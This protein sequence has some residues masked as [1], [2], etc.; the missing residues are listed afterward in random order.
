M[1]G[2]ARGHTLVP[3]PEMQVADART[4]ALVQPATLPG[5]VM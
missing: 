4:N 2:G 1:Y 3:S 5:P